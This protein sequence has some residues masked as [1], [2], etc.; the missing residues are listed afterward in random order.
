MTTAQVRQLYEKL[1]PLGL[2]GRRKIA[3]IGP[4]RA[5]IIVPG[6][7]VLLAFLREFKLPA[8]YYSRAGVRDGIIADL[9]ARNV[10]SE[11]SRL[12]RE[13][14]VEVEEMCRKFG[15]P[16]SHGR[17]VADLAGM[18]FHALQPVHK[19]PPPAGKLVEAAAYLHDVG[20]YVSSVAHHKHSWYVVANSDMPGFTERE[21][22]LVASLCRYHRKALPSPAHN[23][24]EPLTAEEK[25]LVTLAIPI[26]RLADNLDRSHSQRV[27][28]VD[29]KF[30]DDEVVL[31]VHSD[32]EI[33]LETWAAERAGETSDRSTTG[34][35]RSQRRSRVTP[36]RYTIMKQNTLGSICVHLRPSAANLRLARPPKTRLS[37]RCTQMDADKRSDGLAVRFPTLVRTLLNRRTWRSKSTN[38]PPKY[39]RTNG[40][41]TMQFCAA[42]RSGRSRLLWAGLLPWP[43]TRGVGEIPRTS[44][45]T[46]SRS[47]KMR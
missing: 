18:L 10:G 25:R 20:H 41:C 22:L 33:D 42:L 37:R 46:C 8:F 26:L 23:S 28:S 14:R 7:A 12:S 2:S 5:E 35:S 11:L 38:G 3:G 6:V 17:K 47:T 43:R 36:R 9:A 45:C 39:Q 1:A 40:R 13:Q 34:R 31:Q 27:R 4:K 21:R 32:G 44:T 30:R 19:L 24:Y 16:L 29:C 15:V